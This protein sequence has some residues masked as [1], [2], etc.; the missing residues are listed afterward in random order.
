MFTTPIKEFGTYFIYKVPQFADTT[1]IE[2]TA[3]AYN[4]AGDKQQLT[5]W[6][7][8]LPKEVFLRSIDNITMYSAASGKNCAF[9]LKRMTATDTLSLQGDSLYFAELKLEDETL[10]SPSLTWYSHVFYFSRF[11]SFD[12]GEATQLTVSNAYLSSKS[13]KIVRDIHNDDILLFGTA[14]EAIGAIKV[15]SVTDEDGTDNDRYIFS[16]KVIDNKQF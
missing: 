2:L 4:T 13:N 9:S 8:V 14:K 7:D 3:V 16:I 10:Q 12:F 11:E 5:L 6:L 15:L 1:S